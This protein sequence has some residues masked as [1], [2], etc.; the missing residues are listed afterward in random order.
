MSEKASRSP[1]WSAVGLLRGR[2]ALILAAGVLIGVLAD[3]SAV[4]LLGAS[5]WFVVS[6]AVAGAE[7]GSSFSYVTPSGVVRSLALARIATR[8][9]QRLLVHS[10]TLAWLVR[11]RVRLFDDLAALPL[12]LL[13][14]RRRGE[15]LDSAMRD[16]DTLD[17]WVA[18]AVAPFLTTGVVAVAGVVVVAQV[19]PG[20]AVV[21]AV[22]ELVV[23]AVAITGG[24]RT[25]DPAAARTAARDDVIATV[26]A[27][28][29]L[30]SL[31]AADIARQ[32]TRGLLDDF[33]RESTSRAA[34]IATLAARTDILTGAWLLVMI[35]VGRFGPGAPDAADLALAVLVG[36]GSLQLVEAFRDSAIATAEAR[37]AARRLRPHDG[38][39]TGTGTARHPETLTHTVSGDLR[40][41]R[42]PLTA[43]G[44]TQ[45]VRVRPG[46]A[47]VLSGRSGSGKT[48]LLRRLAGESE[49][50]VPVTVDGVN[51][52]HLAPGLVV[53]VSH[54]EPLLAGTVVDNLRLGAPSLTREA[55]RT[56]LDDLG[57]DGVALDDTVGT[58]GTRVVSGGEQRRLGIARALAA[59]PRVLILDE[60]TDG[61]DAETARTV[62]SVIRSRLP[63]AALLAAIH[64][65]DLPA[66]PWA[67][68]EWLTLDPVRR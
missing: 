1:L 8:Y 23:A 41:D 14:R 49:T 50:P 66:V 45:D 38:P 19:A 17:G 60:P 29:E 12:P 27:M 59:H 65:R 2:P 56:L 61:L 51:L 30:I 58:G 21:L 39:G 16:V 48:T 47:L 13:A 55:A 25:P 33:A 40:A 37:S 7:R 52:P 54:D 5:G 53:H 22:G 26:E 15:A 9:L 34:R 3:A 18:T 44:R 4:G 64:D 36:A 42:M 24:L 35:L 57:L 32:R 63:D 28:P 67:D 10:A 11:L 62:L 20:M 31:G 46:A 6:C 43:D 68:S